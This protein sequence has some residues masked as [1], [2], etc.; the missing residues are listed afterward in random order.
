M[1]RDGFS[2][3]AA[4]SI[5]IWLPNAKSGAHTIPPSCG[6]NSF[7]PFPLEQMK[8]AAGRCR[9]AK[10]WFWVQEEPENMGGWNFVRDALQEAIGKEMHYLGRKPAASPATGYHSVHKNEQAAIV[11]EAIGT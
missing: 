3:A 2:S 1:L 7:Y 11:A 10:E 8:Q 5:T 6:W 9:A 4:R